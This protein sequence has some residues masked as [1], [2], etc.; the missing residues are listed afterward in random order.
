MLSLLQLRNGSHDTRAGKKIVQFFRR[1][2]DY[3][4]AVTRCYAGSGSGAGSWC[5]A[6]SRCRSRCHAGSRAYAGSRAGNPGSGMDRRHVLVVFVVL[7]SCHF[8]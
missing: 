8:V 1:D 7:R 5:H 6:R 2:V 3:G 4:S